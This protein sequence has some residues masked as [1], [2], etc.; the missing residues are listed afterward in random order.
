MLIVYEVVAAQGE[1]PEGLLSE[2]VL[3]ETQAQIMTIGEAR[4]V[5]FTA[6]VPHPQGLEIRLV[7]VAPRDAQFVL[8]RLEASA[9]VQ[10]FRAHEIP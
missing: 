6:A 10:S 9:A 3:N 2:E 5:G 8:R 1:N 7:A 4:A